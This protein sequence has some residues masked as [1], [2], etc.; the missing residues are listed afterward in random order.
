MNN[1]IKNGYNG[2][3]INNNHHQTYISLIN[4]YINNNIDYETILQN[5]FKVLK[6]YDRPKFMRHYSKFLNRMEKTL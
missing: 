2:F 3:L 6:K 1:L 4:D 5:S